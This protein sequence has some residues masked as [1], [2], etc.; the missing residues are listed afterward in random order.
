MKK[1]NNGKDLHNYGVDLANWLLKKWIIEAKM[2][3]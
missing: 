2:I 1:Q 3:C